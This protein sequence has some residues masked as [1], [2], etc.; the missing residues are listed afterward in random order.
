MAEKRIS[1]V[2]PRDSWGSALMVWWGFMLNA[3]ERLSF[4]RL[5]QAEEIRIA[6][7]CERTAPHSWARGTCS[8]NDVL[9]PHQGKQ[10]DILLLERCQWRTHRREPL[11]PLEERTLP[12]IYGSPEPM[13]SFRVW[14][15]SKQFPGVSRG[16]RR[17]LPQGKLARFLQSVPR[18][19]DYSFYQ[20]L[21]IYSVFTVFTVYLHEPHKHTRGSD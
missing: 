17:G 15:H 16:I 4:G 20:R 5:L 3:A 12:S 19:I 18:W 7:L 8:W 11:E 6:A 2:C 9:Q 21:Y 1:R 13:T 14:R 10:V